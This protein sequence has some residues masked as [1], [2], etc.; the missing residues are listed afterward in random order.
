MKVY[1]FEGPR[2]R[3]QLKVLPP[4]SCWINGREIPD[5]R[6]TMFLVRVLEQHYHASTPFSSLAGHQVYYGDSFPAAWGEV[7][8]YVP[9][10]KIP[11]GLRKYAEAPGKPLIEVLED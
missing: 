11:R 9:D 7:Y 2:F 5:D 8:R 10:V 1:R 3:A 6:P 4:L